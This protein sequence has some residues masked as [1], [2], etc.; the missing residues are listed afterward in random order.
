M[1]TYH[2]VGFDDACDILSERTHHMDWQIVAQRGDLEFTLG[3]PLE[4]GSAVFDL[5]VLGQRLEIAPAA[6]TKLLRELGLQEIAGALPPSML[7]EALNHLLGNR[8]RTV[9]D[10]KVWHDHAGR[11]IYLDWEHRRRAPIDGVT[12]FRTTFSAISMKNRRTLRRP[13][14]MVLNDQPTHVEV[15][16]DCEK[17]REVLPED[18][19]LGG[20]MLRHSEMGAA[21]TTLYASIFRAW[22]YNQ[23]VYG[24]SKTD[25]RYVGEMRL[26]IGLADLAGDLAG[27]LGGLL[28]RMRRLAHQPCVGISE[29][30]LILQS[31]WELSPVTSDALVEMAT[32]PKIGNTRWGYEDTSLYDMLNAFTAVTTHRREQIPHQ[33]C[34]TLEQL[35]DLLLRGDSSLP[36][37]LKDRQSS[38]LAIAPPERDRLPALDWEWDDF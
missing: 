24:F 31:R 33:D 25:P 34:Q 27:N 3:T 21:P 11:L 5:R 19:L 4:D 26:P 9:G 18:T 12:A 8:L 16:A 15:T 38:E 7:A 29:A 10:A 37:V 23:F 13:T 17:V 14:V 30:A 32:H 20:V 22:C 28:N 35:A 2:N 36:E 6:R 1:T